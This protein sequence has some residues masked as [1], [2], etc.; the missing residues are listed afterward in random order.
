MGWLV[1]TKNN[2]FM[3]SSLDELKELARQGTLSIGDLVQPPN[4]NEWLYASELPEFENLF[5]PPS[6]EE[7]ISQKE[8]PGRKVLAL[9]FLLAAGGGFYSAFQNFQQIPSPDELQL[10]GKNGLANDEGVITVSQS[11]VLQS[12]KGNQERGKLAKNTKVKLLSKRNNRFQIQSDKGEGW[13]DL[14]DV[15]PAYLFALPAVKDVYDSKFNAHRRIIV[16]NPSWERS[17]FGKDQTSIYF[18]LQNTA[19]FDVTDIRIRAQ[20]K[21]QNEKSISEEFFTIQGKI[22][23]SDTTVVGSL[24][25]EIKGDSPTYMTRYHIGELEKR[26]PS[27]VDR[28]I[29]SIELPM[30]TTFAG[31]QIDVVEA[32]VIE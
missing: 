13:I 11:T 12:S 32:Q 7:N 23:A 1:T 10:L 21:D 31:A 22:P 28:W 4:S 18:K 2:Q 15:A 5:S 30:A 25:S 24:R 26:N 14:N 20:F 27:V 8:G 6:I 17:E 19:H 9:F 3:A 29:E 16:R